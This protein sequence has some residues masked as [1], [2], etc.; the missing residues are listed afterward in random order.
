MRDNREIKKLIGQR[1]K[2]YRKEK[3]YSQQQLA[4]IIGLSTNYISDIERG[5][6]FPLLDKFVAIVNALGCTT[7]DI[8]ADVVES[9]YKIKESR[10][11]E[12]MDQLSIKDREI[13]YA[14]LE[15]FINKIT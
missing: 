5:T 9:G 7:D 11:S 1:I 3:G 12:R 15:T 2:R 13:A 10:L 8:F 14:I 4:E 6:K